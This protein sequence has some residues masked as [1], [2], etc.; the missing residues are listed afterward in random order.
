M[1]PTWRSGIAA[2][3]ACSRAMFCRTERASRKALSAAQPT[4]STVPRIQPRGV[5]HI[6]IS[7]DEGQRDRHADEERERRDHASRVCPCVARPA[8]PSESRSDSR[9]RA[10]S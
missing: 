10:W 6:R 1:T 9:R 7:G 2:V 8:R 4:T 5:N 3:E